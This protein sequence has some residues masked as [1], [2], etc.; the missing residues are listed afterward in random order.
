M[1]LDTSPRHNRL[2]VTPARPT[3]DTE[4]RI[5]M[6]GLPV[7][8]PVALRAGTTDPRGQSWH[9]AAVFAASGKGTLDLCRDA[10]MSGSYSGIDPMGRGTAAA[11]P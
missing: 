8:V 6:S 11:R 7:G 5:R 3:L 10:P 1:T 4:L 2:A 9:S